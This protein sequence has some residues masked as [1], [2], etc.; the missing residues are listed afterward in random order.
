VVAAA[1]ALLV[2]FIAIAVALVLI[3]GQGSAQRGLLGSGTEFSGKGQLSD[4]GSGAGSSTGG[5]AA[6]TWT[7][8]FN[9]DAY[10]GATFWQPADRSSPNAIALGAGSYPETL[11]SGQYIAVETGQPAPP[12]PF[13][14]LEGMRFTGW[15]TAPPG[16]AAAQLIDNTNLS[17]LT[18][19]TDVT[20]YASFEPRPSDVDYDS[21]GLPILMYHYFYDPDLG[22]SGEDGNW[23]NIHL[24]EEQLA[25]LQSEGYYY[26][27]WY[28]ANAYL[29]GETTLPARSIMLTSDDGFDSFYDLAIPLVEQYDAKITGFVEGTWF[30]PAKLDKY[31]NEHVFF[32]SH[33]YAFHR[34]GSDGD[35]AILT[36]SY[37]EICED[38]RLGDE[39]LGNRIVYCYP[40]GKTNYNAK[41]AL[42]DSGV[43][44][45]L[46]IVHARAYPMMDPME[47]PRLRMSD[48]ITLDAFID[49]VSA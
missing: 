47:I 46:V 21:A 1:A 17:L 48:G 8:N 20:L 30:D 25:W 14:T 28:E 41:Q 2:A 42:S 39:L 26:P 5:G 16:D 34:G 13:P 15:Y 19:D 36:A 33:S 9:L 12:L 18:P 38:V 35:A 11:A 45:A 10:P 27:T 37:D 6:N 4:G 49:T 43:G 3:N 22:Q 23:M 7:I 32:G 40:F 24:F 29:R 44:V 31:A